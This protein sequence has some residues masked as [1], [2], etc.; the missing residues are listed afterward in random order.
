MAS[1]SRLSVEH[2]LAGTGFS[3]LVGS[4]PELGE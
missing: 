3:G 2:T 4:G 1:F